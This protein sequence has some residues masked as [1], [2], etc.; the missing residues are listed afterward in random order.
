MNEFE[1]YSLNDKKRVMLKI[2]NKIVSDIRGHLTYTLIG[3]SPSGYKVSV[4]VNKEQWDQFDVPIET[5]KIDKKIDRNK[6]R[7]K[8]LSKVSKKSKIPPKNKRKIYNEEIEKWLIEHY[9]LTNDEL[10]NM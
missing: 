9:D 2:S 7:M 1:A 6:I 8:K 10:K 4:M 3:Y 5:R